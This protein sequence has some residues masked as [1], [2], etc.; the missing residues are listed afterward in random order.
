MYRAP[1]EDKHYTTYAEIESNYYEPILTGCI[2]D[3]HPTQQTMRKIGW[4]SELQE[5]ASIIHVAYDL[6]K[7]QQGAL[8]I[9]PSGIDNAVGR[10]FRVVKLSNGIVYPASMTCEIVPEYTNQYERALN[11][12][13]ARDFSL[14]R[15]E[16][17]EN[18]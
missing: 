7:L 6:P 12:F 14:L 2:F 8:F 3:E 11:D 15:G 9:I 5:G 17:C 4:V 16:E 10:V 18:A 1:R 13:R